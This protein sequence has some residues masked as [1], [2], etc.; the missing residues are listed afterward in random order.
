MLKF[1]SR[2]PTQ[3]TQTLPAESVATAGMK[4]AP[5]DLLMFTGLEV[6]APA[7]AWVVRRHGSWSP[8]REAPDYVVRPQETRY[9]HQ[10]RRI[11]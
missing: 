2:L 7:D 4:S 5:G 6:F 8:G 1:D 11:R 3:A 10:E 9:N